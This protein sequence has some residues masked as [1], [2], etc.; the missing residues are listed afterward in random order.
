MMHWLGLDHKQMTNL[1][2][3]QTY[4]T[5]FQK[6]IVLKHIKFIFQIPKFHG[7]FQ[8]CFTNKRG[9][10]PAHAKGFTDQPWVFSKTGNFVFYN[11][12]Y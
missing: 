5:T 4:S 11:Y 7:Q 10:T 1:Q 12:S 3:L 2:C 6:Q 8:R 9:L